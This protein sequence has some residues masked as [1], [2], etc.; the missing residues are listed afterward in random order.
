[1][2]ITEFTKHQE[3]EEII[4]KIETRDINNNITEE[5]DFDENGQQLL[6]ITNGYNEKGKLLL[7]TQYDEDNQL[8]EKKTIHYNSEGKEIGSETEFPD[9][10]LTKEIHKIEGNS[11]T[12]TTE[13]EDGEF[14]GSVQ[15]ILNDNHLTKELIRTNFM[16]KVD[17]RLKYEYDENQNTTKV[18]EQ[19]PKGRFLKAY[20]YQYDENANRTIEEELDKKDRPVSRIIHKYDGNLL[21]STITASESVHYHYENNQIIKEEILQPDGSADI[22]KRTFENNKIINEKQYSIPQGENTEEDFLIMEKRYLYE[23]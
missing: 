22:I 6:R 17:Y 20:A 12:I 14:E 23:E 21:K 1:M 10:S 15:H 13:D 9:G 11:V 19:D 2:K 8:I 4:S 7:I 16:G 18:I 5:I 3:G